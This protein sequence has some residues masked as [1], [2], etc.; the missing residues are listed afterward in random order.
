[1]RLY[2]GIG[3]PLQR[4]VPEGGRVIAG[5]FYRSGTLVGMLPHLIHQDPRAYGG[6]AAQWRPERWL[7]CDRHALERHNLVVN[8]TFL[9]PATT[10]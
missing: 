2:P 6:D 3:A 9:T 5:R 4:V 10:H 7:E 8:T 1:M